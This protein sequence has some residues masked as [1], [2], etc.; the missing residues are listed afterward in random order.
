MNW[1]E[2]SE[3]MQRQQT[4]SLGKDEQDF[5]QFESK[6]DEVL[7]LLKG[8]NSC[9]RKYQSPVKKSPSQE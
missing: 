8:M 9:D 2:I 6:I 1:K 5:R 3:R 4:A 7:Y